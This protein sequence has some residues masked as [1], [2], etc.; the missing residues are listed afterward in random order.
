MDLAIA[1]HQSGLGGRYLLTLVKRNRTL[2]LPWNRLR[3]GSPVVLSL[4]DDAGADS[5]QGVVSA[6]NLQSIQVAVQEWPEGDRF[7]VDLSPDEITRKRQR[8]ALRAAREARGRLGEL[9]G[10]LLGER[11]PRFSAEPDCEFSGSLNA[12]QQAAIRFAL[13]AE[14]VAIIHGPPGTGKTTTVVE[15]I[16]Q[17]IVR[18]EKVLACAPS[19]TAVDNLLQRLAAANLRVVRLGHPARVEIGLREH[20]LDVMVENHENMRWVRDLMREA[21]TLYRKA[22]RY[23]RAKPAP[24]QRQEMRRQAKQLKADARTLERQAINHVLDQA[25]VVCATATFDEEVLGD[26]Q[27]D[28]AVIDEAS[29][30]TEPGCWIP[31]LRQPRRAGRRSL[32]I[33]AHHCLRSGSARRVRP[34]PARAGRRHVRGTGHAPAAGSISHA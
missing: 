25:D 28:L 1:D 17:A 2:H 6:R 13:S 32:S 27:F 3:V 14:D 23:T 8:A 26:R 7:R 29:Q 31:L 24:G 9:R 16:R 11:E 5:Y 33:T 30:S 22:S 4:H 21:E 20:T 12:S 15:L 34:Q 18:E 10:V 19:N